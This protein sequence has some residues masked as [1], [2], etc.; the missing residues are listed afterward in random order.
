M[1]GEKKDLVR[2]SKL[3]FAREALDRG[4]IRGKRELRTAGDCTGK[5]GAIERKTNNG[6]ER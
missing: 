3:I 6:K 4:D 5:R 1:L 2:A